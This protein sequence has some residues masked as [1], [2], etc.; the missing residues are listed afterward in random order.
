[1]ISL[2][3]QKKLSRANSVFRSNGY[4]EYG[5]WCGTVTYYSYFFHSL[6]LEELKNFEVHKM[7]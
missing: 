7:L 1:M 3:L 4:C 6:S 2:D 5:H